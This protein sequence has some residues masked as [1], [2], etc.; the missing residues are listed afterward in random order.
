MKDCSVN[1]N[2]IGFSKKEILDAVNNNR[3]LSLEIELSLACD[4]QC[5]Y[6]Y[7]P[8]KSD[9]NHELKINE[10]R[11]VIIQAR[12]LGARRIILLGGEP[13][14]YPEVI[15]I[16]RF[17]RGLELEVEMFTNGTGITRG[18][19]RQLYAHQVR[20]VLK[21]N[22]F[23]EKLQDRLAGKKGAYRII[24]N[25]LQNLRQAGYPSVDAFLGVSTIMCAQNKAELPKMWQWL[26]DRNITPY[27]EMITPQ[28][29]AEKNTWLYL[30]PKK[31]HDIFI[32]I[33]EIDRIRYGKTWDIQPPIIG[34][35]CLRHQ[36]S[37]LVTSTG[38]VFPCVGVTIPVGNI[39]EQ[40]L[41]NIISN[42]AVI[43]DLRNYRHTI[44]GNCK[45]C[46]N[47]EECYGCRGSAYQL[48]GDY[49]ASDPLCWENQTE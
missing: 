46:K 40:R 33:A 16:I 39:R 10:I 47:A 13:S 2:G 36:F 20:V 5:P 7:V 42:S 14:T 4:F 18:F 22:T 26:R 31:V 35:K 43:K 19:S 27:F 25:G 15:K 38:N 37:C 21:M 8:K 6:C 30:T 3:L 23:D 12:E 44:K 1:I 34:G 29:H 9:L 11:D 28:A 49:L 24:Q 41:Q 48:T 17:I 32:Q 45:T